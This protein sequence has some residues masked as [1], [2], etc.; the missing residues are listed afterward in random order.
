MANIE[1]SPKGF[2]EEIR[3]ERGPNAVVLTTTTTRTQNEVF[4]NVEEAL[5][6]KKQEKKSERIKAWTYPIGGVV[7]GVLGVV[8]IVSGARGLN[9]DYPILDFASVLFGSMVTFL[10]HGLGN[11]GAE[12]RIKSQLISRQIEKMKNNLIIK[13]GPSIK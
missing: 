2:S 12:A 8:M 13:K 6:E 5:G 7:A 3:L 11:D 4:L 9:T 10:S 1:K